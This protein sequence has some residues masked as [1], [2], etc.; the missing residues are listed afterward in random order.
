[1]TSWSPTCGWG[2]GGR[3][4]DH[5]IIVFFYIIVILY[6]KYGSDNNLDLSVILEHTITLAAVP[7]IK[8]HARIGFNVRLVASGIFRKTNFHEVPKKDI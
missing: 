2:P 1:M 8:T 4:P 3:S 7:P 5:L 6:N